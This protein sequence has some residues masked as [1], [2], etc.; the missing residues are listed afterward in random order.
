MTR[1]IMAYLAALILCAVFGAALLAVDRV[2][3]A[4]R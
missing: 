1:Y 3:G 4:W 2:L